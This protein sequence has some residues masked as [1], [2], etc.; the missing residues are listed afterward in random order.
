MYTQEF[1]SDRSEL[2]GGKN[3]TLDFF[4]IQTNKRKLQQVL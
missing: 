2:L 3:K 4:E 1:M